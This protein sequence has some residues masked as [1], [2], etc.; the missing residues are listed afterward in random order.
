MAH[1]GFIIRWICAIRRAAHVTLMP[2]FAKREPA[3]GPAGGAGRS[4]A[5]GGEEEASMTF[6]IVSAPVRPV[7]RA[8]AL[9]AAASMLAFLA[10]SSAS[11]QQPPAPAPAPTP[12]PKAAPTG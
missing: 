11:A 8:F 5:R 10:A 3:I 7:R 1:P 9:L 4:V 12:A 2:Y 6:P